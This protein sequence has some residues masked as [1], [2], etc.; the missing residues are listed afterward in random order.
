MAPESTYTNPGNST[1]RYWLT[2]GGLVTFTWAVLG[3]AYLGI[4]TYA[5]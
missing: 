2:V 1:R 4:L 3:G 5:H